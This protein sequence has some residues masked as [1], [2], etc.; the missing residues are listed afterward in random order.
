MSKNQCVRCGKDVGDD[1]HIFRGGESR[2]QLT[3]LQIGKKVSLCDK[4][5]SDEEPDTF[6]YVEKEEKWIGSKEFTNDQI[7]NA[8]KTLE[9][10][11]NN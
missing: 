8:K 10:L 5:I 1:I 7:E 3:E 2:R 9:L 11:K 4:L 6:Q